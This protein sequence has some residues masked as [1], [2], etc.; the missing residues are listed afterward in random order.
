MEQKENRVQHGWGINREN[1]EK[2]INTVS[3]AARDSKVLV[4]GEITTVLV[5]SLAF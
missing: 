1:F 3:D 2:R 4:K 5:L